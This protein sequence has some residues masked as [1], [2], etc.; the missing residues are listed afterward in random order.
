[1][2]SSKGYGRRGSNRLADMS[3]P[4]EVRVRP[5]RHKARRRKTAASAQARRQERDEAKIGRARR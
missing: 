4:P 1:M 2:A 5:R 3:L